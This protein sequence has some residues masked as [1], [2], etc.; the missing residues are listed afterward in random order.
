[1]ILLLM[2]KKKIRVLACREIQMSIKA[3]VHQLLVNIIYENAWQYEFKV[4]QASIIHIDTGSMVTFAGLKNNPES[5][6]S[7]EGLDL[8]FIEEAQTISEASMRLLI[9]TVRKPGSEIWMAMNPRY[10]TDYVYQ[11]F[12]VHGDKNVMNIQ[13]NWSDN[14]WFPEVLRQEM[15]YDKERDYGY[16]LHTWEGQLRPYGARPAFAPDALVWI[17]TELSSEPDIYG[18]DLS[19]SGT[20]ALTGISTSED[21]SILNVHSAAASTKVSLQKMRDW[22]GEIDNTIVVDSARPEVIQLLRDQGY[23]V[24]GSKKGAGS[25]L[26]G[27]DKL[28]KFREIRFYAG[29]EEAYEEM[30]KL[31]FDDNENLI[32]DRDFCD[33]IRYA[34]EKLHA[35]KTL[36]WD[37]VY[38]YA[39]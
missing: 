5:V 19:Y 31:G 36:S 33:S 12:I 35:F 3:S 37:E 29:T 7:T 2:R 15:E 38:A 14:P 1:M 22:L 28:N 21:G 24:R 39:G 20:N 34:V 26:R 6:K 9:P 11:R 25:V 32:G 18:L 27:I 30:S 17:G 16:Y 23:T 4:T 8:V 13:V 10:A